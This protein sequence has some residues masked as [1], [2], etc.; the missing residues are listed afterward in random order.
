MNETGHRGVA[1]SVALTAPTAVFQPSLKSVL[2][3]TSFLLL[4]TYQPATG[5]N[6]RNVNITR[7]PRE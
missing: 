5:R 3:T 6:E 7:P 4:L 2:T 1:P